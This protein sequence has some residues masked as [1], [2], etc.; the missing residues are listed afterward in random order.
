MDKNA[1]LKAADI[2]FANANYQQA[3]D[4]LRQYC[5][6][7][8]NDIEQWFRLATSE[9]QV[10]S[11]Q[12]CQEAYQ[13]C[14]E[15]G[16]NSARLYLFA[17]MF[18]L[19][20]QQQQ[21]GLALLSLGCDLDQ[22]MLY[23]FQDENLDDQIRGRSYYAGL[24]LRNHFTELSKIK[25]AD[26]SQNSGKC[27]GALWPQT[28][29]EPWQYKTD[30]QKPHLFYLPEL[31]AQAFWPNQD[32]SWT[33]KFREQF[34]ELKQEFDAVA[35]DIEVQGAPYVDANFADKSF[36]KL[37]GSK[38][39]TA[40][41]LYQN[42]I[43]NEA[44]VERLPKLHK[45]L[46]SIDLYGLNEHPYEVFFSLL[47]AGQHIVP[48]YGL[49]N[50]SLTVHIPFI[51]G[52]SGALTVN[53]IAKPWQCGESLIFD[54][55]FEHEAINSSEQ[56]RI[57]LIFSIWHPELSKQERQA[58]QQSFQARQNWLDSREQLAKA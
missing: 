10:G 35:D 4:K 23:W 20:Q 18:F 1:L 6:L 41:H 33:D 47:K 42:G 39:W 30:N 8:P 17:G 55:S 3:L 50:H 45:L 21:K 49:S 54:D 28:H 52:N 7:M 48:H 22:T 5:Q 58:I 9:E 36:D 51:V 16:S 13:H 31:T 40:L 12:A 56:D 57:V 44:L 38:N 29:N 26:K 37:A 34:D 53:H 14:I 24:A 43:K 11:K 32:F 2:N 46:M 27:N 19:N 25:L 15:I